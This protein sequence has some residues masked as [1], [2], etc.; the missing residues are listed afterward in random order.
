MLRRKEG[1]LEITPEHAP[2]APF[3]FHP[4][5]LRADE[6]TSPDVAPSRENQWF[7]SGSASSTNAFKTNA[8]KTIVGDTRA[9]ALTRSPLRGQRR[10]GAIE[11]L[12]DLATPAS[13]SPETSH[14]GFT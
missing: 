6:R 3:A 11:H 14:F 1:R 2:A 12:I 7:R 9:T 10:T 8:F 4:A 13:R 5:G